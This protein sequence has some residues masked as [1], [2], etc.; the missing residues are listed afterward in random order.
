MRKCV[1][2]PHFYK[3][4]G[5]KGLQEASFSFKKNWK[6]KNKLFSNKKKINI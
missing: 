6:I 2:L 4:S 3:K 1:V 5:S